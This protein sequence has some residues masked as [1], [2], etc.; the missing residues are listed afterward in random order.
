[1][2]NTISMYLP[3]GS[4]DQRVRSEIS[5]ASASVPTSGSSSQSTTAGDSWGRLAALAGEPSH[6]AGDD[7]SV[8]VS[9]MTLRRRRV[10]KTTGTKDV[11]G[12]G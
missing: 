9:T 1:V 2:A 8:V 12:Q 10:L 7:A 5:F 3:D 11:E 6:I 4:P